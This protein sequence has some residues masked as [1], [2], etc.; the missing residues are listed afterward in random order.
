MY[1]KSLTQTYLRN[2]GNVLTDATDRIDLVTK[3]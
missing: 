3:I 1:D 2:K